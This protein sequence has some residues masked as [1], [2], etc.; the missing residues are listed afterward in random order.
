LP[1]NP[2]RKSRLFG[3]RGVEAQPSRAFTI[4]SHRAEIHLPGI[5]ALQHAHDA[6]HVAQALGARLGDGVAHGGR[7][8]LVRQLPRQVI[9]DHRDFRAFLFGQFQAPALFIGARAFLA[10]LDHLA[11]DREHF[12]LAHAIGLA[13]GANGDVLI[14]HGGIDQPQ[15]R[16]PRGVLVAHRLFQ[17]RADPLSQSKSHGPYPRYLPYPR[18]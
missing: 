11:E 16:Q 10:L 4:G 18:R 3:V 15:R 9:L 2:T 1:A 7:H 17:A 12:G 5:L 8:F 13:L 6:P 14:L